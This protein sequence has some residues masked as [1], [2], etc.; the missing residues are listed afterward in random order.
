MCCLHTLCGCTSGQRTDFVRW[1]SGFRGSYIVHK[2]AFHAVFMFPLSSLS[3]PLSFAL[4]YPLFE[5]TL[6]SSVFTIDVTSFSSSKCCLTYISKPSSDA[7][8]TH[9]TCR[10]FCALVLNYYNSV[11]DEINCHTVKYKRS[12][13]SFKAGLEQHFCPLYNRKELQLR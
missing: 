5:T 13:N 7:A 6:N 9:I 4:F 12:Q 10:D 3:H 1:R 11:F 8:M 2:R